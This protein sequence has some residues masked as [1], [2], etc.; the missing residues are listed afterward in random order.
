MALAVTG[1]PSSTYGPSDTHTSVAVILATNVATTAAANL[2]A[3][4]TTNSDRE[5][6]DIGLSLR[7]GSA[8]SQNY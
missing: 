8:G 1:P 2:C 6:R 5:R 7:S 4:S 3:T